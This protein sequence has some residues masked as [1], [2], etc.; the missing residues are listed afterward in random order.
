[1]KNLQEQEKALRLEILEHYF[2]NASLGT[3]NAHQGHFKIKGEYRENVKLD[4]D[5]LQ[6][7]HEYFTE[8]EKDCV[9]WKPELIKSRYKDLD[10]DETSGFF[11]DCMTIT[12]A[13]PSLTLELVA[14]DE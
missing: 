11:E 6:A 3:F 2:P 5:L 4:A 12:P 10:E 13:L 8:Q 1:M 9:K 7:N 14:E